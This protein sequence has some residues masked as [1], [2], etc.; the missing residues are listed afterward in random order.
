M[1]QERM[2]RFYQEDNAQMFS[3]QGGRMKWM[4]HQARRKYGRAYIHVLNIGIG[5]GWLEE[6]CLGQGWVVHSIDIVPETVARAKEKGI[7]AH[8]AE[9]SSMPFA[10]RYMDVVFC[11]EVLEHLTPE[12]C[13]AGLREIRRVLRT[14]GMFIGTTPHNE[15]LSMARV[16]CDTCG[17]VFHSCGHLQSF[18]RA[19]QREVLEAHGFTV[20]KQYIS[21]FLPFYSQKW[22]GKVAMIPF[23]LVGRF[24]RGF[25]SITCGFVATHSKRDAGK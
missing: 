17:S 9:I 14:D 16:M 5:N 12:V 7:D 8:T 6:W 21:A 25:A 1:N 20:R 4:F 22:Y 2:F 13:S 24:G 11:G 15:D 10:E 18:T 19:R 3:T 23:W